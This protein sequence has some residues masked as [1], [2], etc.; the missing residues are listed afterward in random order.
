MK[1][2]NWFKAS[3]IIIG[4]IA[5]SVGGGIAIAKI[6]PQGLGMITVI[7]MIG[8]LIYWLKTIFDAQDKQEAEKLLCEANRSLKDIAPAELAAQVVETVEKAHQK[9]RRG[10]Q[11]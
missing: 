6:G 3:G 4:A 7:C 8:A 10:R 5:G 1:L 11:F 9:P 2:K